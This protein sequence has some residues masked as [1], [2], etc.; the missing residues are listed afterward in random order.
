MSESRR[1]A[2]VTGASSGIGRSTCLE[3]SRSGIAVA[4]V[5]RRAERLASLVDEIEREGGHAKAIPADL[6][7]AGALER[8]LQE[9]GAWLGRL[10]IVV[11]N[12]GM[13]HVAPLAEMDFAKIQQMIDLNLTAA[14]ALTQAAVARFHEQGHGHLVQISSILGL[15]VRPGAAAY[16]GTK[17][18]LEAISEAARL[19]LADTDVKITCV[20]PGYIVTELHEHWEK[21]PCE[22]MGIQGLDPMDVARCVRFVVEQPTEVL[23]PKLLVVPNRQP[24]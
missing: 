20:E 21:K 13:M 5:A 22:T 12:A 15:K 23:I 19:E 3:L 24:L 16:S 8:V 1:V 10:D 2:L 9:A 14:F 7:E 4:A 18:A 11:N 6:T 17:H